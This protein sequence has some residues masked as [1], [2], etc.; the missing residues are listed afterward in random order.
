MHARSKSRANYKGISNLVVSKNSSLIEGD[1]WSFTKSEGKQSSPTTSNPPNPDIPRSAH[2]LVI[3]KHGDKPN[4][5]R[6]NPPKRLERPDI[7]RTGLIWTSFGDDIRDAIWETLR[8]AFTLPGGFQWVLHSASMLDPGPS[9][10]TRGLTRLVPHLEYKKVDNDSYIVMFVSA[11]GKQYRTGGFGQVD[12][13]DHDMPAGLPVPAD[14][15]PGPYFLQD[16]RLEHQPETAIPLRERR[17][18]PAHTFQQDAI[19]SRRYTGSPAFALL[20]HGPPADRIPRDRMPVDRIPVNR[21]PADRMPVDR[22]HDRMQIDPVQDVRMPFD[23]MPSYPFSRRR[24]SPSPPGFQERR[25]PQRT[26]RPRDGDSPGRNGHPPL[27]EDKHASAPRARM[28]ARL[29]GEFSNYVRRRRPDRSSSDSRESFW[30]EHADSSDEFG[31][32]RFAY[33]SPRDHREH[34]AHRRPNSLRSD[35]VDS[36]DRSDDSLDDDELYDQLLRKFTGHGMRER[37]TDDGDSDGDVNGGTDEDVDGNADQDATGHE[38]NHVEAGGAD[39]IIGGDADD[40]AA[41]RDDKSDKEN[42]PRLS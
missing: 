18:T 20:R 31:G 34:F 22:M 30:S 33:S 5:L 19:Y 15:I 9:L 21:M 8:L 10:L 11:N 6:L 42:P 29:P 26:P 38:S 36:R 35:D 1:R 25:Y 27:S 14:T 17:K 4:I 37:E 7:R 2:L 16:R 28:S 32:R 40:R 13:A 24:Y 12:I 39:K 3:T 23:Q 41:G